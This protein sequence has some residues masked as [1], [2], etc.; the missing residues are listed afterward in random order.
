MSLKSV[1]LLE[2][3]VLGICRNGSESDILDDMVLWISVSIFVRYICKTGQR[4]KISCDTDS[5][6]ERGSAAWY[7]FIEN[8]LP[9]LLLKWVILER[10]IKAFAI[11][12]IKAHKVFLFKF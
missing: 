9:K 6:A 1:T 7:F 4:Y 5:K 12:N 2:L 8:Y 11:K 3:T 10:L